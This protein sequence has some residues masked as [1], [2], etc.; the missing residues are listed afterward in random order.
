M[1]KQANKVKFGL[2]SVHYAAITETDDKITYT[3]PLPIPGGV[4]LTLA[5]QGDTTPFYADDSEYFTSIANNGYDGT[6]E[7]EIGRAHV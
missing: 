3:T 7:I 4:N 1:A 6:L 5:P 2:S